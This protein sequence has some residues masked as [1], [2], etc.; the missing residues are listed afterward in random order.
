MQ[1]SRASQA[2][3]KAFQVRGVQKALSVRTGIS[4]PRLSR[5]AKG[6][7]APTTDNS[8]KLK[9]DPDV[10]IDPSWWGEPPLPDDAEQGAA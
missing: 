3:A 9:N 10:P 6:G 8:Q 7:S 4:Q 2:L 1:H 5:L